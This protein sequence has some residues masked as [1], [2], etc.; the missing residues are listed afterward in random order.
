MQC[1]LPNKNVV[2]NCSLNKISVSDIKK[3]NVCKYHNVGFCKY[4]DKCK[5]FHSIEDCDRKCNINNCIK[6]HR[7]ICRHG[8]SCKHKQKCQFIHDQKEDQ[9]VIK[10]IS[11]LN[12]AVK[13][14]SEKNVM[15]REKIN[16][17]EQEVK[18]IKAQK[19]KMSE[20]ISKLSAELKMV[21]SMCEG[22]ESTKSIKP[23]P[24]EIKSVQST[25]KKV[26][27]KVC[28]LKFKDNNELKEHWIETEVHCKTCQECCVGVSEGNGIIYPDDP[29]H[30]GHERSVIKNKCE[31]CIYICESNQTLQEHMTNKHL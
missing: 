26:K 28:E 22:L 31:E 13:D 27:C 19:Q 14:L 18:E 24:K 1:R 16:D 5:L 29:K 4:R 17:L 30:Q 21:R 3:E 15:N 7:K 23:I 10:Q 6:R 25:S 20:S 11:D 12:K 9:N 2:K 8:E